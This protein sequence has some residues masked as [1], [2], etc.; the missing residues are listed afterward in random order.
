MAGWLARF[1]WVYML[2]ERA[3]LSFLQLSRARFVFVGGPI[4]SAM[5]IHGKFQLLLVKGQDGLRK[6]SAKGEPIIMICKF[7]STN[8][9]VK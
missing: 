9:S 3:R 1:I 7:L 6:P 4:S 2:Y 5:V 8:F